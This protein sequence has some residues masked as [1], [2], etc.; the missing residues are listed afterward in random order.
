MIA[1]VLAVLFA[2]VIGAAAFPAQLSELENLNQCRRNAGMF[3]E[4]AFRR[5]SRLLGSCVT[6]ILL[7]VLFGIILIL[8]LNRQ[9]PPNLKC[10]GLLFRCAGVRSTGRGSQRRASPSTGPPA[11]VGN[12]S[13]NPNSTRKKSSTKVVYRRLRSL[14]KIPREKW[15]FIAIVLLYLASWTFVIVIPFLINAIPHCV[16]NKYSKGGLWTAYAICNMATL[17]FCTILLGTMVLFNVRWK[18]LSRDS[19]PPS[20][21]EADWIGHSRSQSNVVPSQPPPAP[22]PTPVQ[23]PTHARTE[24]TN[25]SR[26]STQSADSSHLQL[27]KHLRIKRQ[28]FDA[29]R[30]F[31]SPEVLF[32]HAEEVIKDPEWQRSMRNATMPVNIPPTTPGSTVERYNSSPWQVGRTTVRRVESST[33]SSRASTQYSYLRLPSPLH[34]LAPVSR[35]VSVKTSTSKPSRHDTGP[36]LIAPVPQRLN[37]VTS[38]HYASSSKG[39]TTSTV[40]TAAEPGTVRIHSR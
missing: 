9:L 27:P 35:S 3:T 5:P 12:G 16:E 26:E 31:S 14:L 1:H 17:V 38:T 19:R 6:L 33:S 7:D 30:T 4:F 40:E 32:K 23:L 39:V 11:H 25:R 13:V 37:L 10:L 36:D 15:A 18:Q 34:R 2:L 22:S 24:A 20:I 21:Q 8:L 28:H 29:S